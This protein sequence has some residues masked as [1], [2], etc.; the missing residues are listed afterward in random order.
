MLA[1]VDR[2]RCY[3]Y[4]NARY[5]TLVGRS[6][7][8]IIGL[9]VEEVIG[10]RYPE[11]AQR[12]DDTLAGEVREFE[13]DL[14]SAGGG[15]RMRVTYIPDRGSD[16]EIEG[17]VALLTDISNEHRAERERVQTQKLMARTLDGVAVL[18]CRLD[19]QGIVRSVNEK[20]KEQGGLR[21]EDVIG[22][23]FEDTPWW[24]VSDDVRGEV[25]S[26]VDRAAAGEIVRKD[27]RARRYDGEIRWADFQVVPIFE[28]DEVIS[29]IA[30]GTDITD[31]RVAE[32][33]ANQAT[34]RLTV[35]MEAGRAI[36]AW[37][38]NV[39]EDT[40][41]VDPVFAATF[42]IDPAEAEAGLPSERFVNNIHEE[43]RE[44]VRLAIEEAVR[45][46]EVYEQDYRVHTIEGDTVWVLA[47]G[48]CFRDEAGRPSNFPGLAFDITE[49]KAVER[50]RLA[51]MDELNH[52]VKNTLAVVQSLAHQSFERGTP[53]TNTFNGRLATLG[54]AHTLLTRTA[55]ESAD[56]FDVARD[57][58]AVCQT[59]P[60]RISIGG[61][62]VHLKSTP[63]LAFASAFHELCTNAIKY[64]ALSND[65][66][67]V[68][69]EWE[70]GGEP[71]ELRVRWTE[72]DGPTPKADP[73]KGF[74]LRMIQSVLASDI[75][76]TVN[77]AFPPTGLELT[78]IV[79]L[80][81][82]RAKVMP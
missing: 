50:Q 11:I 18:I 33:A 6:V 21:E 76:G 81:D 46:G 31:R 57:T 62:S 51:L 74:G 35:A 72:S 36:G 15:R 66:G 47:R 45:T 78:A 27:M 48:R 70:T 71:E 34:E 19:P 20:A 10:A 26:L 16:G 49:R 80:R 40:H 55:W 75:Q 5:A 63:A 68:R 61:P 69:V 29:L 32:D 82:V 43:D 44:R 1:Q 3:T 59:D 28:N 42:G 41:T 30:S 65:T 38:W 12:L 14:P 4:A 53:E 52:R 64:G 22:V 37:D 25:R 17:M 13:I 56:L 67:T 39:Q 54:A 8:G 60:R 9:T 73:R 23:P 77:M 79:P 24:D 58:V 2:D 7:D